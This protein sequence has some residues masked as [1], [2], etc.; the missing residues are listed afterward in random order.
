MFDR[1]PAG[2]CGPASELVGRLA[3]EFLAVDGCY[4]CG[5]G[6]PLLPHQQSHA[7]WEVDGYIID[8][9][10]DQF[11]DTGLQGWVHPQSS[12]WHAGFREVDRRNGFCMPATWPMY[13]KS[14]YAAMLEQLSQR[15]EGLGFAD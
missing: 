10:H 4:V 8:I 6:H 12:T 9:T 13:P 7:W 5:V 14:G 3:K 2:A 1:F 11:A 15:R